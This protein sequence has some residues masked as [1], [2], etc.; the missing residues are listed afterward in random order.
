MCFTVRSLADGTEEM[1]IGRVEYGRF[2]SGRSWHV[3]GGG[4]SIICHCQ[5][6]RYSME[7]NMSYEQIITLETTLVTFADQLIRWYGF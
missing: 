7:N 1:G 6:R 5:L 3:V 4:P 2:C